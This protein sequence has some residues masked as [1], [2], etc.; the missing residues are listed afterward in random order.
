MKQT[1]KK[2]GARNIFR[3][4]AKGAVVAL[5]IVMLLLFAVG[6][7]G[8][9]SETVV[10]A[11]EVYRYG[12]QLYTKQEIDAIPGVITS[13][14]TRGY[15]LIYS[16][17]FE[18]ITVPSNHN[19][20]PV[21]DMVLLPENCPDLSKIEV[22]EDNERYSSKSGVLY[23]KDGTV[24]ICCPA[25]KSGNTFKVPETVTVIGENAFY[26]CEFDE[27]VIGESVT[28][29]RRGAFFGATIDE[30]EIPAGV[31]NIV[32]GAFGGN[33]NLTAI[34]VAE[35]N[36][37]YYAVDGVLY[38]EDGGVEL[39]CYPAGREG[40]LFTVP[41]YVTRIGNNAFRGSSLSLVTV[42]EGVTSVG[43]G[44][45]SLCPSVEVV[46]PASVT[47]FGKGVFNGSEDAT[48][49]CS[50]NLVAVPMTDDGTNVTAT[51]NWAYV[52]GHPT[53]R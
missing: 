10:T 7:G 2:I 41:A 14:V 26:G 4:M 53:T 18:E 24:L 29:I 36:P 47:S 40:E 5:G 52:K 50:G 44:A 38:R 16:G 6:C 37:V 34:T 1:E 22:D 42:T 8:S 17:N 27:I 13:E 19:N 49:F 51:A 21:L 30:M 46:L 12:G 48:V 33:E 28:E 43:D 15:R 31:V 32:D 11:E 20:L 23:N 25:Q 45:F 3:L 35:E 9:D 39:V